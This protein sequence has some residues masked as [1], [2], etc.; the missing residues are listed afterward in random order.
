MT[1]PRFS[2]TA[3]LIRLNG[4]VFHFD[5]L[6]DDM[7]LARQHMEHLIAYDRDDPNAQFYG[8]RLLKLRRK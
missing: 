1:D 2:Y 6:N 4:E 5:F 7:T 3:R 8:C